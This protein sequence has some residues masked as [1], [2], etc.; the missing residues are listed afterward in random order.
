M[1][2]YTMLK[3]SQHPAKFVDPTHYSRENIVAKF[4]GNKQYGSEDI[5]LSVVE[6]QGSA[7]SCLNPSLLLISAENAF[8][9]NIRYIKLKSPILIMRT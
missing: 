2:L 7:F 4:S 9:E 1:F 5:M 8:Y 6:E 3:E